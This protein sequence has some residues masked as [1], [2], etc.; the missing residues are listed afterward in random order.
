[1]TIGSIGAAMTHHVA[2]QQPAAAAQGVS[3][4]GGQDADGDSDGS[5]TAAPAAAGSS[6]T[7][8]AVNLMA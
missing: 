6:S 2:H 3:P 1:M 7:A 5:T 8:H 4:S